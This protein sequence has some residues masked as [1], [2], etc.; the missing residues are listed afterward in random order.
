MLKAVEDTS[1]HTLKKV[2]SIMKLFEETKEKVRREAR[3]VY[4]FELLEIL[5]SQVYCK[6]VFLVDNGIAS[7]NTANKYLNRL[8]DIGILEKEKVGKEFIFKNK[9]LYEILK[10][11]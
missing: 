4:S 10:K 1:K 2:L 7:R 8:V 5:F 9:G 6:Y 3:E 11:G